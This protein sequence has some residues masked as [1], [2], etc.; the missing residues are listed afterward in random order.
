MFGIAGAHRVGKTTLA[1]EVAQKLGIAFL[2]TKVADVF[3]ELGLSVRVSHDVATMFRIQNAILDKLEAGYEMAARDGEAW[4]TD[5]TPLDVM[6]YTMADIRRDSLDTA[7]LLGEFRKHMTRSME[8]TSRNFRSVLIVSPGIQM[9][10]DQSKAPGCP[11]YQIHCTSIL[12]S[13][14]YWRPLENV[15]LGM[16][17]AHVTELNDR[18]SQSVLFFDATMQQAGNGIAERQA[19]IVH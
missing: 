12:H 1:R 6:M 2:E 17:P 9:V 4:I 13:M 16:L 7:E 10:E 3:P 5:R 11:A 8:I 14:A 19:R 18:V 15:V